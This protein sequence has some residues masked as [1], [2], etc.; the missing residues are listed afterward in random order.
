MREAI[1]AFQRG[2]RNIDFKKD[3]IIVPAVDLA[4]LSAR[5]KRFMRLEESLSGER[6]GKER[7]GEKGKSRQRK[8]G[9]QEELRSNL[10]L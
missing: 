4:D 5:A 9:A 7:S 2:L 3:L 10:P 1:S 6:K 8:K